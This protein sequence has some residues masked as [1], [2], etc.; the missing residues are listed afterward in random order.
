MP[1]S[2]D[3]SKISGDT[4]DRHGMWRSLVART[5][6]VGEAPSSNL[7]IPIQGKASGSTVGSLLLFPLFL[8]PR[9]IAHG[10]AQREP[11]SIAFLILCDVK[12]EGIH[13]RDAGG[14][15]S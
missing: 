9:N 4:D 6:G 10:R 1:A 12:D 8:A 13:R 11:I 15:E 7:G 5:L 14:A 2:V 3:Q